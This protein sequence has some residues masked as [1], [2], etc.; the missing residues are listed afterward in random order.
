MRIAAIVLIV[1]GV[2]ALVYGGFSY[3]RD[4]KIIDAGP[5]EVTAERTKRVPLPPLVGVFA[6]V[7][8]VG[9]LVVTKKR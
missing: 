1:V 9:M 5:V 8:G 7:A 6:I 4:E 3:T 2:L